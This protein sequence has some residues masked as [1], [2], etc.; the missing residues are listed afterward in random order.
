TLKLANPPTRSVLSLSLPSLSP[1]TFGFPC[2]PFGFA[3]KGKP[4]VA[5]LMKK[6][7]SFGPH[8]LG[9]QFLPF[10][11]KTKGG[12]RKGSSFLVFLLVLPIKSKTKSGEK[13]EELEEI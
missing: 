6:N 5:K 8:A 11:G 3:R 2:F 4:K 12:Q 1:A 7:L 9:L 10:L 13:K